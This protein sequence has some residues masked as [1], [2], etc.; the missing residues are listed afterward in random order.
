MTHFHC[1]D[2]ASCELEI[3]PAKLASKMPNLQV[4]NASW[5]IMAY[6]DGKI[7]QSF[8]SLIVLYACLQLRGCLV[9]TWTNLD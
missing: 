6:L 4:L 3:I 8:N 5:N 9:N 2:V 1:R 7:V